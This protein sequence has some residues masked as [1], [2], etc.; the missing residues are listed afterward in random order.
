[1]PWWLAC[2]GHH[3]RLPSEQLREAVE[4][5]QV[6]QECTVFFGQQ[7]RLHWCGV[8]VM[9]TAESLSAAVPKGCVS[10]GESGLLSAHYL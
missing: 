6:L 1:M 10:A 8:C 3:P 7:Q 4:L 2:T 5:W 9:W